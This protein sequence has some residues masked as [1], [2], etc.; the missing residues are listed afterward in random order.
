MTASD[1]PDSRISEFTLGLMEATGWY[2]P[3]YTMAEPISWGANQGCGF[4]TSSCINPVT[5]YPA[6]S[7]FCGPAENLGCY[8][9]SKYKGY[10]GYVLNAAPAHP[11]DYWDNFTK[12]SDIFSNNCPYFHQSMGSMYDCENP[13]N[14]ANPILQEVYM[15]GSR[16]FEVTLAKNTLKSSAYPTT[17]AACY[18][19]KVR[20]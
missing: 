13:A 3:D 15:P 20:I 11:Y 10:C 7:E 8:W 1:I 19:Y 14:Q 6:F 12:S 16:C 17:Q 18:Q 4:I 5:K 2:A 9:G